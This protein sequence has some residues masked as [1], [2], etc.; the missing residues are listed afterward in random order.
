MPSSATL[1][2]PL[3]RRRLMGSA[4]AVSAFG[5][6]ALSGCQSASQAES[7]TPTTSETPAPA[8][9]VTLDPFSSFDL[10]DL[11]LVPAGAMEGLEAVLHPDYREVYATLPKIGTYAEPD[12]EAIAQLAPD[13]VLAST[14]QAEHQAKLEAIAP[15]TLITA[16]TSA[17]WRQAASEVAAA[18]GQQPKLAELERAYLE[19]AA[20]M[21]Q[22]HAGTLADL[23]WVLVWQ[24]IDS[25]FSVRSPDS[26]GGQVLAEIGVTFTDLSRSTEDGLDIKLSWE[27]VTKINDAD[28][29]CLQ[30]ST[31]E[32]PNA[33]T[34]LILANALFA[35]V[36][37]AKAGRTP[38]FANL[39]PGSYRNAQ[40]LL[41]ELDSYLVTLT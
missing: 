23:T 34:D 9:V 22:T 40:A 10:F 21:K 30:K 32:L 37:A 26:N 31:A 39:T 16:T 35:S 13:L 3:T 15:T 11:G 4:L 19:R 33:S 6:L 17:T 41:D 2:R 20:S 1:A 8:T 38:Q 24:G 14:G 27:E 28:V 36:P 25:G 7:V 18:V 5:G 12:F 29:I